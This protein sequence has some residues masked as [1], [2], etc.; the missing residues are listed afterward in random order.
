MSRQA[1][2]APSRARRIAVA[3]PIPRRRAAP[4][5]SATLPAIPLSVI[6]ATVASVYAA[7]S[8]DIERVGAEAD[9][10]AGE[11]E[12]LRRLPDDVAAMVVDTGLLRQW[13]PAHHGGGEAD[14]ATVL[15]AVER[16]AFY[17][18]STAWFAMIAATTSLASGYLPTEW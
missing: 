5:T 3:R 14:V 16:L 1:T 4:V 2:S 12:G 17:D 6:A 13:V 9:R 7:T 15:D 18:G 11:T 10:R 8:V